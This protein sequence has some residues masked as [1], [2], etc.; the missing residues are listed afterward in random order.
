MSSLQQSTNAFDAL[1]I[2][3]A[4]FRQT[5]P[6]IASQMITLIYNLADTYFVGMLNQPSQTAAITVVYSSFLMLTAISNLFGVGGAS[7]LARALGRKAP[8]EA[9]RIASISFWFGLFSGALF[10]LLFLV[11]P[12]AHS[13][14]LCGATQDHPSHRRATP[15]G[16]GDPAAPPPS[17]APFWPTWSGRR[18]K[19]GPNA[20]FGLS[21]GGARQPGAGPVVYSAPVS[22]VGRPWAPAWPPVCPTFSPPFTSWSIYCAV[23]ERPPLTSTPATCRLSASMEKRSWPSDS[24]PPCSMPLP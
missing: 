19:A 11:L 1:P 24:P 15:M 14:V 13:S 6:A 21:L 17:S 20:S 8:D 5:F 10:C 18:G 23:R 3:Q 9:R 2:R 12:A 22:G 4:V 16:G 7:A